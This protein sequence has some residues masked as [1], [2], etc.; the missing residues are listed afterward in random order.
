[1]GVTKEMADKKRGTGEGINTDALNVIQKGGD[2][3]Q[4]HKKK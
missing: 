2:L 3:V 4:R 1:M